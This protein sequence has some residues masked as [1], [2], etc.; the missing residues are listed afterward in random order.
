MTPDDEI[1]EERLDLLAEYDFNE[2]IDERFGPGTF[3]NHELLDRT[4]LMESSWRQFV[5]EHPTCFSDPGLFTQA[6]E[7]EA[8]IAD[9]YQAVGRR[10]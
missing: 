5:L 2:P 3:G 8:R 4:Y 6:K 7:I 10:D 1:E 9:F